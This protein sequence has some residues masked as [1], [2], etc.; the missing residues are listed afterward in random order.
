ML[1]KYLKRQLS[2]IILLIYVMWGKS[3][4]ALAIVAK[5]KPNLLAKWELF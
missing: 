1:A 3:N 4:K 5:S 2:Y